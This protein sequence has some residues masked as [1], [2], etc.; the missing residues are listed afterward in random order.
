[1]QCALPRLRQVAAEG[2][3]VAQFG[4]R[5]EVEPPVR[6]EVVVAVEVEQA[7]LQQIAQTQRV[8]ELV[9]Q[10]ATGARAFELHVEQA[11]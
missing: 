3:V 5:D 2:A 8:V 6:R 9:A 4:A 11:R 10:G 7:A 1:M